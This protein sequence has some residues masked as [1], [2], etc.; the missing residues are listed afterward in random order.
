MHKHRNM[1][2]HMLHDES[3]PTGAVSDTGIPIAGFP[4]SALRTA[5]HRS[6]LVGAMRAFYE[7]TDRLIA[8]RHPTC[9]NKGACCDFTRLGSR[10]YVTAL[11]VCYYLAAHQV[12][13]VM[14]DACP[15]AYDGSC[16]ARDHRPL[17]CRVYHCD[18]QAQAWQGPL[19]EERLARLR[20]LHEEL[21]VAYFYA[22]W[23]RILRSLGPAGSTGYV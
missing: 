18:P 5:A 21:G 9:W 1:P 12:P 11:E 17:G 19:M 20:V 16:H 22:D 4:S 7:E 14:G 8:D 6:D 13:A 15:H 2:L 10:L 3:P 23:I